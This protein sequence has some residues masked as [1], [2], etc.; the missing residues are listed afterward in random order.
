MTGAGPVRPEDLISASDAARLFGIDRDRIAAW[1]GAGR[2]RAVRTLAGVRYLLPEI[3][4]LVDEQRLPP[5][6]EDPAPVVAEDVEPPRHGRA[7]ARR[8]ALEL[9]HAADVSSRDPHALV[10][11]ATAPYTVELIDGV[12]A[13]R[14]RIDEVIEERAERW[15]IDRMPVV[16]RNVLRIA[17]YELLRTDLPTAVVID[18][19]VDLVK[20]LST[21]ESGRFVH[22]MLARIARDVRAQK[23]DG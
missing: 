22:G 2:L 11:E 15:T 18:Q 1:E 8:H 5:P 6:V 23:H 4:R 7:A 9:L 14:V 3:R 17:V 13:E 12:T 10:D 19:A 20:M 21:E 16:D